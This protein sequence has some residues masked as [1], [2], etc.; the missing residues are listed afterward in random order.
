MRRNDVILSL[1]DEK[2]LLFAQNSI[3]F[4]CANGGFSFEDKDEMFIDVCRGEW[5][6][7]I[8]RCERQNRGSV[9]LFCQD[10]PGVGGRGDGIKSRYL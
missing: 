10:S 9:S 7:F 3:H 5:R 4:S 8:A 2:G 6:G 1:P